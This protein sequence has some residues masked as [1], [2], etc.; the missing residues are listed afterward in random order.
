MGAAGVFIN[1]I[2]MVLNLLPLPPLDGGRITREPAAA[3]AGARGSRDRAA[4]GFVILHRAAVHR[5]AGLRA[6]A[7]GDLAMSLIAGASAA[8]VGSSPARSASADTSSISPMFTNRVLSGM[9]PTGALH[10]GH[11]H[12][13]LKNWIR[14][15]HEYECLFLRRRLARADHALRR[16]GDHRAARL[17]H[18][19]RLARGRRRSRARDASSSSRACRRTPSCTCCCR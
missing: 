5:R 11:Y 3:P 10:L 1:V 6:V 14:L 19:D 13:V 15:Q 18:G 12:G 9:R 4:I 7:A 8:G 2:F 16:A 17:G